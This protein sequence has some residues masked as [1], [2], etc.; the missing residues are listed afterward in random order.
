MCQ[1]KLGHSMSQQK[2][3]SC[4]SLLHLPAS[5]GMQAEAI[6]LEERAA[7]VCRHQSMSAVKGLRCV[8]RGGD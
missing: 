3:S 5:K 6:V 4:Q 7:V 2:N 8:E 1:T